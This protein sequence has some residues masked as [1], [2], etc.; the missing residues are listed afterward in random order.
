MSIK[1]NEIPVG[2]IGLGLMGCSITTCLADSRAS[3]GGNCPDQYRYDYCR[4]AYP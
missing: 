3:G 1:T 2:V 4:I